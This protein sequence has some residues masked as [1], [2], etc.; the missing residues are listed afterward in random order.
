MQQMTNLAGEVSA[1]SSPAALAPELDLSSSADFRS[2]VEIYSTRLYRL[3]YRMTA[4]RQDAED[5][6]QE[7]FLRAYRSRARF[8][9]RAGVGT[10]LHRICANA[11]LDLLR[12]HRVR[13]QAT[14]ATDSEMDVAELLPSG[15]A[16]PERLLLS[17]EAQRRIGS[18]LNLL[19]PVER[20][21]F[22]LRHYEH[23]SIEEIGSALGLRTS[24]T[25]NTIFRG[26]RKLR[27]QLEQA[28]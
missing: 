20:A 2:V 22:V 1:D 17:Q 19:T 25:K 5:L 23:L 9:A 13:P 21:A 15:E 6:V 28:R 12:R 24:A 14:T 26:V 16:S 10:W 18:A 4:N 7:T 3:A 8:E 11:A 27:Q